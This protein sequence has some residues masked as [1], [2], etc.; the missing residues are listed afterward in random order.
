MKITLPIG[1]KDQ[2]FDKNNKQQYELEGIDVGE[3]KKIW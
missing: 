1:D 3:I 2:I